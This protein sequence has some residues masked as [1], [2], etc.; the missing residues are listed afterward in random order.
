M[1]RSP[2]TIRPNYF[3]LAIGISQI[4]QSEEVAKQKEIELMDSSRIRQHG[5]IR[6]FVGGFFVLAG[7][8]QIVVVILA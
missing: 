6:L 1:V 3:R 4:L 7:S 2:E 5:F 8:L